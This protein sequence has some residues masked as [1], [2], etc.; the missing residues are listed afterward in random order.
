MPNNI[1]IGTTLEETS[2]PNSLDEVSEKSKTKSGKVGFFIG[3]AIIGV[4]WAAFT[5]ED[6]ITQSV[7]QAA[8]YMEIYKNY[9][10]YL[11]A[12][13]EGVL[14]NLLEPITN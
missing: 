14:E 13:R 5:Y 8:V 4:C 1:E 6:L 12:I 2:A 3:L 9:V 11:I 10:D 7:P